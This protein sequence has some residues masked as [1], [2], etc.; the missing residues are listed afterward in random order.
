MMSSAQL[1]A[2]VQL[3]A[4]DVAAPRVAT[5]L[6]RTAFDLAARGVTA[7]TVFP[8]NPV[9]AALKTALSA[10]LRPPDRVAG[11]RVVRGLLDDLTGEPG[12]TPPHWRAGLTPATAVLDVALALMSASVG[13][14]FGWAGQ[15]DGR[16][17]HTIVPS[18][19]YERA[20]VGASSTAELTWHTEDAF[21][22]RRAQLLMLTCVRNLDGVGSRVTSLRH[23]E[24]TELE[25]SVLAEPAVT[26]CPDDS[27]P[28]EWG[29]AGGPGMS[30]VWR[31][32]DGWSLRYDSAYSRFRPAW[33]GFTE[34]YQHLGAALQDCA[35]EIPLGPGDV[36][37][38][39]NDLVAHGRAPFQPRYDGT[40][41]WLK[42]TLIHLNRYRP[43]TE[44]RESGYGQDLVEPFAAIPDMRGGGHRG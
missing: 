34:A 24:L 13:G 23:A 43:V 9:P 42:R 7:D 4:P 25:Q 10:V 16:L 18:R 44:Q 27:Y 3:P 33:S 30:T 20:Q 12:P 5:E 32:H 1:T 40:D 6:A 41:R 17:V 26:I 39:D 8:A 28:Q 31:S 29:R 36:M 14:L 2:A 19:G 22:P 21:H 38:I 11:W 35:V 15:Q 37:L